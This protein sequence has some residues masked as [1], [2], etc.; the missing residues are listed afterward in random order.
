MEQNKLNQLTLRED[1][2]SLLLNANLEDNPAN[3][4]FRLIQDE[5]LSFANQESSLKEEAQAILKLQE[6]G[7][8]LNIVATE[9]E[10]YNKRT[11]AIAGGFSAGKSEFISSLFNTDTLHLPSGIQPTTA[12]PTYVVDSGDSS[13]S[14]NAFNYKGAKVVLSEI[15]PD[16]HKNLS[17]EFLQSFKFNLRDIMPNVFISLPMKFHHLCFIDTPGY[18]PSETNRGFTGEDVHFAR[19]YSQRADTLIWLIGLDANGT[20]PKTD[21][22]FLT[23]LNENDEEKK[24]YIVL[25]KADLKPK[26]HIEAILDTVM[27]TLDDYNIKVEGISAYSSILKTEMS[28]RETALFNFL[29]S[30]NT[31]GNKLEQILHK[32]FEVD[33]MY[34]VAIL[35][36][37]RE[38]QMIHESLEKISRENNEV[39]YDQLKR[40]FLIDEAYKQLKS[41]ENV[42]LKLESVINHIFHEPQNASKRKVLELKDVG[43]PQFNSNVSQTVKSERKQQTKKES[44]TT[45]N[46]HNPFVWLSVEDD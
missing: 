8:E 44:R 46:W 45:S 35:T 6:I 20:I 23:Q 13:I 25:N 40:Y 19:D 5:F 27:D 10:F 1:L 28:Y 34:Q 18:N 43:V 12:I 7:K 15:F 41:L 17:H 39:I 9:A 2:V 37:I 33:H 11:V 38:A 3:E 32:L 31:K 16:F 36:K 14:I 4:Y 24:I 22:D 21:L 29:E 26:D 30:I 42:M